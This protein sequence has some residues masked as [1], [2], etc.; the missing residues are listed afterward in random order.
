MG[1]SSTNDLS[2]FDSHA[3]GIDPNKFDPTTETNALLKKIVEK[4]SRL[5]GKKGK[6]SYERVSMGGRW[7]ERNVGRVSKGD[8]AW[9][10]M[11]Y[12]KDGG[13]G[14]GGVDPKWEG[15]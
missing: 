3:A 14:K 12:P 7:P 13:K 6:V 5:P 1:H 8:V 2:S 9:V 10:G 15:V 4:K 11:I